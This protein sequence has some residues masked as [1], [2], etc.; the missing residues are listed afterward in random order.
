MCILLKT[1]TVTEVWLFVEYLM[2]IWIIFESA[3]NGLETEFLVI[4][5]SVTTILPSAI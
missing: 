2:A 1:I 4:T 3:F 5:S